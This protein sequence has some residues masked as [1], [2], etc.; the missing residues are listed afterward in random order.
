MVELGWTRNEQGDSVGD[1]AKTL[2][3]DPQRNS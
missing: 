1:S 3:R 2:T